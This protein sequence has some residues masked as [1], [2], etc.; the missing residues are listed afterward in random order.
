MAEVK[1]E[2]MPVRTKV[3]NL[4]CG[5]FF[6]Q[7]FDFDGIKTYGLYMV[8]Q[9]HVD[10]QKVDA[11]LMDDNF[12]IAYDHYFLHLGYDQIVE[13]VCVEVTVKSYCRAYAE[14]E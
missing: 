9:I 10:T 13:P 11:I 8:T 3:G 5:E 12:D 14:D 6:I 7:R 1:Y 4:Y 2:C